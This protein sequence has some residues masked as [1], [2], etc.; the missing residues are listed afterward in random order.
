MVTGADLDV[1]GEDLDRLAGEL[2]AMQQHLDGQVRR[3][4]AL[5]DRAEARWRSEA[6]TAYRAVHRRVAEDAV[7]VRE[8]L[9]VLEQA[10]RFSRDGFTAQELD[11]LQRLRKAQQSV[12]V[13]AEAREL[14]GEGPPD[15][16]PSSRILGI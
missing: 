8:I 13:A 15:A 3:M 4:D 9:A 12:D 14:S 2:D 16:G 1:S 11:T 6:A 10:V 7:R 5:V